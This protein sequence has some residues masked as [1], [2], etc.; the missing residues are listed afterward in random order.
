MDELL[1]KVSYLDK[2][3]FYAFI[4]FAKTNP[5]IMEFAEWFSVFGVIVVAL[6]LIYLVGRERIHALFTAALA[7]IFSSFIYCLLY[8][9][10]QSPETL[11]TYASEYARIS[12]VI[13]YKFPS[14]QIYLSF[15][16]TSA[17]LLRGH[18]K[19]GAF[20]IVISTATALSRIATGLI[21]PSGA[22]AS[23]IIGVAS[24]ILA[25]WFMEYFEDF[26]SSHQAE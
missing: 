11:I 19:L 5:P 21:Y 1:A 13:D 7:V 9:L 18:K 22:I 8:L 2:Q 4:D 23:L 17:V 14:G 25:F 12:S 10:W 16:I 6:S 20:L 24:G 15:S 26:W 3:I